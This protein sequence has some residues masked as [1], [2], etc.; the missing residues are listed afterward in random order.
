V[1][2]GVHEHEHELVIC[3]EDGRRPPET[4]HPPDFINSCYLESQSEGH[5]RSSLAVLGQMAPNRRRYWL[6]CSQEENRGGARRHSLNRR[7][8]Q[9]SVCRF[10]SG[11]GRTCIKPIF[12]GQHF[13][14]QSTISTLENVWKCLV[15]EGFR[16]I[17]KT[18]GRA[19]FQRRERTT[20]I[21]RGPATVLMP[22]NWKDGSDEAL[23]MPITEP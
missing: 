11:S 4:G 12:S 17:I 3:T 15:F 5:N 8:P 16:A 23:A 21:L 9:S 10:V 18:N 6:R 19:I 20:D 7:P 13:H 1:V 14:N 22:G 2:G